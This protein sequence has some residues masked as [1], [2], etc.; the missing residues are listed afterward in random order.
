MA[1]CTPRNFDFPNEILIMIFAHLTCKDLKFVRLVCQQWSALAIAKLFKRIY[2]SR[3]PKDNKVFR[4]ITSHDVYRKAVRTLLYDSSRTYRVAIHDI[5]NYSRALVQQLE[6]LARSPREDCERFTV[7]VVEALKAAGFNDPP[8]FGH[9]PREYVWEEVDKVAQEGFGAYMILASQE[10]M[11]ARAPKRQGKMIRELQNLPH[12]NDVIITSGPL[13]QS[14]FGRSW[15]LDYLRP[16]MTSFRS[17]LNRL[18]KDTT[19]DDDLELLIGALSKSGRKIRSLKTDLQ[20]DHGISLDL[21]D[22]GHRANCGYNSVAERLHVYSRLRVLSLVIQADYQSRLKHEADGLRSV[23]LEMPNLV[24]LNLNFHGFDHIHNRYVVRVPF[25]YIFYDWSCTN[26]RN[27][28]HLTLSGLVIEES[29]LLDFLRNHSL[30]T[31]TLGRLKLVE[32]HWVPLLAA[33]QSIVPKIQHIVIDG[34]LFKKLGPD[35]PWLDSDDRRLGGLYRNCEELWE[36]EDE[37]NSLKAKV[38]A[39]VSRQ[40]SNQ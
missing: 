14:P 18:H 20:T 39:Y 28:R 16:S 36:T 22:P 2:I 10:W 12:L 23:L 17:K 4:Q 11:L 33:I 27:L 25:K 7:R 19:Y 26:L 38:A 30:E 40:L 24:D 32:D 31:F 9:L 1:S 34:S 15:P 29:G 37:I 6:A 21:F 35:D 5:E 3:R 13:Q 8:K